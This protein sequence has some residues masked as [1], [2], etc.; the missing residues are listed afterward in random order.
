MLAAACQAFLDMWSP[1]F[2]RVLVKSIGLSVVLFVAVFA[3]VQAVLA[4]LVVLPWPWLDTALAVAA[5]LGL[6]AA[7]FFLMAPVTA[8]FAG[9]YLDEIAALVE[10]RH[11]P[12]DLAGTPLNTFQALIT[13]FQFAALVLLVNL[14]VLPTL[15]LGVGL[16]ALLLANAYLLGREYFELIAMRHMGVEEARRLRKENVVQ[17][18]IAGFV[19]AAWALVPFVNFTVPLFATAFFVHVFKRLAGKSPQAVLAG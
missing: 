18:L 8:L 2:R 11:Y 14:L 5:G 4:A 9:L 10:R 7:F 12:Q 1:A 15:L 16:F 3:A 17:V 6:I 13:G 19:P